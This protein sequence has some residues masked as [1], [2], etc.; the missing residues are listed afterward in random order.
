MCGQFF[1]FL[2]R[3]TDKFNIDVEEGEGVEGG[4]ELHDNQYLSVLIN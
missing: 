1:Q 4:G 3:G 2:F